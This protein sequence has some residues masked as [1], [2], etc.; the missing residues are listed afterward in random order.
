MLVP[1]ATECWRVDKKGKEIDDTRGGKLTQFHLLYIF[2]NLMCFSLSLS[3]PP[4]PPLFLSVHLLTVYKFPI[5]NK[6]YSIIL[7]RIQ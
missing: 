2:L 1:A 5:N 6:F 3:P 4:P 7:L